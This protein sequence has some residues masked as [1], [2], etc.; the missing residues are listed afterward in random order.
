MKAIV[1]DTYG[2]TDVLELGDIG[3]GAF[4]E[5]EQRY[6][7]ILDIGGNPSLP[8]LRRALAPKGTLVIA[9]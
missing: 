2:S 9:V 5:G 6:D 3:K 4:A 7:V 1:H 8:R